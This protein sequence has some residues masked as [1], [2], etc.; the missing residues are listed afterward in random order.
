[1]TDNNKTN[2]NHTANMT[3]ADEQTFNPRDFDLSENLDRGIF[4]LVMRQDGSWSATMDG[5][6]LDEIP[7]KYSVGIVVCLTAAR[8]KY[9]GEFIPGN[10]PQRECASGDGRSGTPI[11][12]EDGKTPQHVGGDCGK[13]VWNQ[14]GSA[15]GGRRGKACKEY[16]VVVVSFGMNEPGSYG[17]IQWP[18]SK[19][20]QF[21]AWRRACGESGPL[22]CAVSIS[23]GGMGLMEG[24]AFDMVD[25]PSRDS[26]EYKLMFAVMGDTLGWMRTTGGLLMAPE[27]TD[28]DADFP[29]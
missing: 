3:D 28:A 27:G 6:P 18:P 21:K 17:L 15:G 13:C 12:D 25:Q 9:A 20:K 29:F 16:R 8:V 7:A 10:E 4:K 19:L 2:E 5:D 23:D 24:R 14:F 22:G 1:V 26:D 11:E